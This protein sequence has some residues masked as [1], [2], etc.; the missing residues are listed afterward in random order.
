[1]QGEGGPGVVGIFGDQVK[2]LRH[3]PTLGW[4]CPSRSAISLLVF[5]SLARSTICERM[6]SLG[7][8]F[9]AWLYLTSLLRS[10]VFNMIGTATLMA[11]EFIHHDQI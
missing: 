6:R 3:L 4:S 9:D 7:E 2:R 10:E 8:T 5:P 11:G 1:V